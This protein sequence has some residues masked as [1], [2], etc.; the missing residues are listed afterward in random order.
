[1]ERTESPVA[2]VCLEILERQGLPM[3]LILLESVY[4]ALLASQGRQDLT[5][6]PELL[7]QKD[8]QGLPRLEEC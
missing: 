2:P 4:N 6:P 3:L 8:S 5:V 1:M 7:A